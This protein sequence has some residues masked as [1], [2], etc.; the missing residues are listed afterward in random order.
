MN[1]HTIIDLL[2]KGKIGVMP[3]DTIYGII[4]S[5]LNPLTVEEIYALRK[6]DTSKPMIILISSLDD[7][8][9]FDIVL[10]SEQRDFLKKVW[11]NPISVILPC[12]AERF[13]YLHRGKKSLAFRMPDNKLLLRILQQVGPLV[14]PS[15]NLEKEKPA[16]TINEAKKYFRKKIPF[17]VNGG[18]LKSKP[19]TMIR[20]YEDGKQIVLREGSFKVN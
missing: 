17:F 19:S 4:G 16:E 9:D 8:S 11:P 18:K 15:A 2:K 6:R 1:E 20:L 7:L 12:P 3:T 13:F 10:S 5:A 14:A